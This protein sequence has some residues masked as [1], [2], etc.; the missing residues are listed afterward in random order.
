MKT[1]RLI[2]GRG[3]DQWP[4]E[5]ATVWSSNTSNLYDGGVA[6]ITRPRRARQFLQPNSAWPD[7][8]LAL[9]SVARIIHHAR[10][11]EVT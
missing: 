7:A 9:S 10:A 2:K 8:V 1:I 11:S 5:T 4:R 3:S 6:E